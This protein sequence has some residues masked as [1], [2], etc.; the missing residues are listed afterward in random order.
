MLHLNVL[1]RE[2]S[3]WK[4]CRRKTKWLLLALPGPELALLF[5]TGQ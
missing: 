5:V 1:A 3:F 2:D 4:I